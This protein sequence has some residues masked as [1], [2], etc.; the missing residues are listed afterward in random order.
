MGRTVRVRLQAPPDDGMVV[1]SVVFSVSARRLGRVSPRSDNGNSHLRDY[2]E[3][4]ARLSPKGECTYWHCC[5]NGCAALHVPRVKA[6]REYGND[7]VLG[8]R[9][10]ILPPRATRLRN[11]RCHPRRRIRRPYFSRE[12]LGHLPRGWHGDHLLDRQ[13]HS[14]LLALP[15]AVPH[16]TERIIGS[17][18]PRVLVRHRPQP[19]YPGFHGSQCAGRSTV[20]DRANWVDLLSCRLGRIYRGT[21][22]LSDHPAAN[23][24]CGCGYS[25]AGRSGSTAGTSVVSAA[26]RVARAGK[27][28]ISASLNTALDL[29]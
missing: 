11:C 8:R 6:Q 4:V 5:F 10:A 9:S 23:E 12:I 13:R 15:R 25:V 26:S 18:A 19:S 22:P 28:G 2:V 29:S 3:V 14:K 21:P 24:G 17:R 7:A 20:W 16:G 27:H 1:H